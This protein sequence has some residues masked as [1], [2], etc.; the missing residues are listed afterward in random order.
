VAAD[1]NA[2][3]NSL[4]S[5]GTYPDAAGVPAYVTASGSCPVNNTLTGPAMTLSQCID[6][7]FGPVTVVRFDKD[8]KNPYG[9]QNSLS[10][11][12][13]PYKDTTVSISYLRVKGVHLGSFF[14]LN[15]PNP[16]QTVLVH[17]D[18]GATTGCKNTYFVIPFGL[19]PTPGG[20]CSFADVLPAPGVSPG[21]PGTACELSGI[22][23]PQN[24]AIYFEATSRWNSQ[25]N[26]LLLNINKRFSDHYSAEIS[27]TFSHTIDDGPNPSFVLVPQDSMNFPAEKANSADDVRHKFV[28]NAVVASPTT[29]SMWWRDYQ[30][31]GIATLQ[32]SPFFTKFAGF[33]A[34]GDIF[35]NN[36]RVGLEGRDTF[37]G[38]PLYTFDL[39]GSR[40][41]TFRESQKLTFSVEAYNLFNHVNVKYFNTVYGSADFCNVSPVPASCGGG[42]FF[43]QGSPLST[44]GTPR[45]VFNP[46]QLQFVLRYA[47]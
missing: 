19:A 39:R 24:Y 41:F 22:T 47:F 15:Q 13:Q 33:D 7:F 29:G 6:S 35:G 27:Y 14:N 38:D 2:A 20:P 32:S 17:G 40:S 5:T 12:F 31:S 37:R 25:F 45:A 1:T 3:L 21:V 43:S 30:L 23:C 34:N 28:A 8:H 42:P 4:L 10:V 11:D 44:Y 9:I 26:G 16:Q 46:R 18:A 36:D